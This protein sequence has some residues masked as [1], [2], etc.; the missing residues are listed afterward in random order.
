M[1]VEPNSWEYFTY[2]CILNRAIWYIGPCFQ[3]PGYPAGVTWGFPPVWRVGTDLK[4]I[5]FSEPAGHGY[6]GIRGVSGT[7]GG[8]IALVH[9]ASS[10][11]TVGGVFE[12]HTR[13]PKKTPTRSPSLHHYD[14]LIS[15]GTVR[16]RASRVPVYP[17][18][19]GVPAGSLNLRLIIF[20]QC[21]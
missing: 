11:S 14:S 15:F 4:K 6:P 8:F 9:Y 16:A 19:F 20:P 13:T 7:S 3:L 17:Q 2:G 1:P 12:S 18:V 21:I 10:K 5:G